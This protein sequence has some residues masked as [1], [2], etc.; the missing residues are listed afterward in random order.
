M[1][2][3]FPEAEWAPDNKGGWTGTFKEPVRLHY[4]L[5]LMVKVR[6]EA[7]TEGWHGRLGFRAETETG[8]RRGGTEASV[9][10]PTIW[11]NPH[12]RQLTKR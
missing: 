8:P 10:P 3:P 11:W 4:N 6:T 5:A 12:T 2:M 7:G 9:K 1:H